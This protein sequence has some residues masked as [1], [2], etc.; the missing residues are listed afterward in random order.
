MELVPQFPV[1]H[2]GN[3][4]ASM[5]GLLSSYTALIYSFLFVLGYHIPSLREQKRDLLS[6]SIACFIS[7]RLAS[8][9]PFGVSVRTSAARYVNDKKSLFNRASKHITTLMLLQVFVLGC[10]YREWLRVSQLLL[11][12]L[13]FKEKHYQSWVLCKSHRY[14]ARMKYL[15]LKCQ[16]LSSPFSQSLEFHDNITT[17]LS[18]Q[19]IC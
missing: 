14:K 6:L 13:F 16:L 8:L 17:V 10:F 11:V 2:Y 5:P 19:V 3:F 12:F 15:Y 9:L 18:H 4:V 1:R 7:S